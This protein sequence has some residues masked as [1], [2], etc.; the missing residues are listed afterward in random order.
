[1]Y[2]KKEIKMATSSTVV[3]KVTVSLSKTLLDRLD[4]SIPT[5]KRSEFIS[6][7]IQEKLAMLEQLE[8]LEATAGVW[9][10]ERY[11]EMQSEAD[12]DRW[13]VELRQGWKR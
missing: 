6:E 12:I 5:R 8:A 11:P 2:K 1:M 13:L 3:Q 7:A 4:E 10:D 9:T